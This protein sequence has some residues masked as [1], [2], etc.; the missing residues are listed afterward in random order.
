MKVTKKFNIEHITSRAT[1]TTLALWNSCLKRR[2]DKK[3]IYIWYAIKAAGK[4]VICEK[5]YI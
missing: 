4:N 5:K 1:E 2:K 3:G